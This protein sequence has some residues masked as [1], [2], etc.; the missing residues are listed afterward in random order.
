VDETG[1]PGRCPRVVRRLAPGPTPKL[2]LAQRAQLPLSRQAAHQLQD[3][4]AQTNPR[5][6]K[7]SIHARLT[8]FYQIAA[9]DEKSK[10]LASGKII[11]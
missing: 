2:N 8:E 1:L 9:R 10:A 4:Y 6:L 11:I 5:E 7:R 3:L